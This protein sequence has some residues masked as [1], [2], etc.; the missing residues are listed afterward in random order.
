M[1]SYESRAVLN[2]MQSK[3]EGAE[4]E[5]LFVGGCVRNAILGLPVS[6]A[7][8]AT[9]HP[10][11]ETVRRLEEAGIKAVPT[12]IDHGTVTAVVRGKPFEITSLRKDIETDGRH[13]VVVYTKNWNEDA[14]RRDFTMNTLLSD[15]LG[16][17]YD[18]TGT[19]LMDLSAG[20]VVFVG[21]P[22]QRIA[23]DYLR[24]LRFFRFQALYGKGMPD[25]AALAACRES[26][27]QVVTLSRERITQEFI[28]I[29]M[30]DNAAGI[31]SVMLLNN[32]MDDLPHPEWDIHAL[33]EL[34][35]M[36]KRLG[37]QSLEA[38]FYLICA[39]RAEHM[40]VLSKY[41][42]FSNAQKQNLESLFEVVESPMGVKE[43]LYR[44]G[45]EIGAQSVLISTILS[46]V[47]IHDEDIRILKSWTIPTFP[48]SGDD[49][50]SL[51]IP[52]GPE[53]GRILRDIESWWIENKFPRREACLEQAA[54][55]KR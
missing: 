14:Q 50:K 43:R 53:M 45:R 33:K 20:R 12:G 6:D 54:G 15:W 13:A 26:A 7:D 42:L 46:G 34:I 24:I 36:Q 39:G 17:V 5:I 21:E 52:S 16:N 9:V 1:T 51:G 25:P 27:K 11:E 40:A 47:R 3:D 38:R 35:G 10:P 49:L 44:Y 55:F 23:E 8:L 19:G 48:V 41:L 31:L 22:A 4:P 29:L 37:A 28:K 2:A 18:P 32:V 30:A